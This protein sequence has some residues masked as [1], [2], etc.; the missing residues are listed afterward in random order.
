MDTSKKLS[1]HFTFSELTCKCGCGL[2]PNQ[3]T[4]ESLERLRTDC[5]I[6]FL[7]TSGARCDNYSKKVSGITGGDHSKGSAID[8]HINSST[9]RALILLNIFKRQVEEKKITWYQIEIC[10]RHIH[11]STQ[12]RESQT[13]LWGISK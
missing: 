3:H 1:N 7:I 6:P 12:L 8:I 5:N 11:I 10:D 2:L 9:E 4:I 13:A